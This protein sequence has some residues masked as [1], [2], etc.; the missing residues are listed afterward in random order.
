MTKGKELNTPITLRLKLVA[1]VL[2]LGPNSGVT[3]LFT[4]HMNTIERTI[5]KLMMKEPKEENLRALKVLGSDTGKTKTKLN[6]AA[7]NI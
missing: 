5:N 1:T 4:K 6:K 2:K 7:Q 3:S